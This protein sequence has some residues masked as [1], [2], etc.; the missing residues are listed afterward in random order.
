MSGALTRALRRQDAADDVNFV[1][2]KIGLS[3]SKFGQKVKEEFT[4]GGRSTTGT[5]AAN[6]AAAAMDVEDED[7]LPP[8]PEGLR[9]LIKVRARGRRAPATRHKAHLVLTGGSA[10][11][12]GASLR[13]PSVLVCA[14]V[15]GVQ[16]VL[17]QVCRH[18]A[19]FC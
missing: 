4:A 18:A 2:K 6:T 9:D 8:E 12:G 3:L 1:G 10:R 13:C 11:S 15:C 7:E 5:L 19:N 14:G 17:A 16:R